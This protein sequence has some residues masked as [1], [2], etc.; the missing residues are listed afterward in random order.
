MH[1][2]V[3]EMCTY[4]HISVTKWRIVGYGAGGIVGFAQQV[5]CNGFKPLP[6]V[7]GLVNYDDRINFL[8]NTGAVQPNARP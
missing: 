1:H 3:A 2:S 6:A 7:S 8:L 5:Y 4:V